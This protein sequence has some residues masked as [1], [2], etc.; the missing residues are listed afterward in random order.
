MVRN[1]YTTNI[2]VYL[3][4]YEIFHAKDGKCGISQ[5]IDG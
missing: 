2:I 1:F 3:A 5:D 4:H